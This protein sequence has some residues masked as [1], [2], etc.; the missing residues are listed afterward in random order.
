MDPPA[1]IETR[2][3]R[4]RGVGRSPA[5]VLKAGRGRRWVFARE[6][7]L[8]D[9]CWALRKVDAWGFELPLAHIDKRSYQTIRNLFSLTFSKNRHS[10]KQVETQYTVFTP[11]WVEKS[12]SGSQESPCLKPGKSLK[13]EQESYW[14]TYEGDKA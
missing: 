12:R 11:M 1:E 4:W 7:W 9:L 13:S 14:S 10:P 6:F 8:G 5:K 3:G 2:A